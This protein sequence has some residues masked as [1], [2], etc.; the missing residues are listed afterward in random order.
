MVNLSK[1]LGLVKNSSTETEV[2][3]IGERLPKCT[4]FRYFNFRIAQGEPAKEDLLLQDNKTSI[5]M[6]KKC[7]I[8]SLARRERILIFFIYL[9]WIRFRNGN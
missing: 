7:S 8:F 1:K 2:V 3:A 5:L 4:W 6:K 9:L